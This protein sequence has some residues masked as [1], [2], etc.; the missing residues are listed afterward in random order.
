MEEGGIRGD[1]RERDGMMRGQR[2]AP[3]GFG[4]GG[5]GPEPRNVGD[6]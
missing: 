1:E 6:L 4:E 3:A 2:D 5:R